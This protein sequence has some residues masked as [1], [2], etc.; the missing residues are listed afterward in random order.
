MDSKIFMSYALQLAEKGRYTAPPNPWVGCVIVK[1]GKIV[2]QG[3]HKAPG[4]AHAEIV[5]L[6]EAKENAKTATAYVTLEPC[7]HFGK[8][9]PCVEALIQ[10][11]IASV[12]ISVLDPDPQVSGRGVE[13]LKKANMQVVTGV[14]EEEAKKSLASY[15]HHRKTGMPY[16]IL[17]AAVSLDGKMAAADSSSQWITGTTA[18]EDVHRQRAKAGAILIGAKTA[19]ID[20]PQLTVR[21]IPGTFSPLRVVVDGKGDLEAKGPLF[22]QTLGK[23]VIFTT[24]CARSEVIRSWERQGV[25][26]LIAPA[27]EEGV[28]L[29]F[30]CSH[31]G[32]RG[33]LELLVEGGA[34]LFQSFFKLKLFQK[35]SLYY[36][37]LLIGQKGRSFYFNDKEE[38]LNACERLLLQEVFR[39]GNDVRLDYCQDQEIGHR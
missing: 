8:T 11:G 19:K 12:V 22:D 29:E 36:G 16:V 7:V 32:K 26:V 31:L 35:L 23:T 37:N 24:S 6:Q 39:L 18:R 4:E 30:V 38:N 13:M 1:E 34:T 25:E 10:G 14:C 2:G 9:P 21:G 15:L 3:F 5:A 20:E 17:K 33:V 27:A 28:N